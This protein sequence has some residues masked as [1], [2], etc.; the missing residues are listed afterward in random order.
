MFDAGTPIFICKKQSGIFEHAL[1]NVS[2]GS[3]IADITRH[4]FR[5]KYDYR[6][7]CTTKRSHR[8][9][10]MWKQHQMALVIYACMTFKGKR[11]HVM[12]HFGTHVT[13]PASVFGRKWLAILVVSSHD[14]GYVLQSN[15]KPSYNTMADRYDIPFTSEDEC[16][17]GMTRYHCICTRYHYTCTR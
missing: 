10:Y 12:S 17:C 6:N 2:M 16:F 1:S 5:G 13:T 8:N 11:I 15:R 9:G 14:Y 3:T 7:A 4:L